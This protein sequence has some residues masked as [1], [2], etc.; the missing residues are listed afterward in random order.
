MNIQKELKNI[1]N[2]YKINFNS[3]FDDKFEFKTISLANKI[4]NCWKKNKN[5]FII[6]NGGSGANAIHLAND[7]LYGAGFSNK[8]GI[9]IEALN[10]NQAVITCLSND[11]GYEFIFSEQIKVKGGKGDLLIILSGSGNSKNIIEAIKISKKMKIDTFGIIGFD[12]GKSKK[13]LDDYI[14]ILINDMQIVEDF[15]MVVGHVCSKFFSRI[16][17]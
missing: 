6:G 16:K 8:K 17:L 11:V 1:L 7:L 4:L 3:V 13:L 5:I 15:Q 2:T 10:S 9:K 14:H 12:G